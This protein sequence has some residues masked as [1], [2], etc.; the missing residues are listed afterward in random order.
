[1]RKIG[2]WF[3]KTVLESPSEMEK[4][5]QFFN[6][7]HVKETLKLAQ[8]ISRWGHSWFSSK[9]SPGRPAVE[10]GQIDFLTQL[11]QSPNPESVF[12]PEL[13]RKIDNL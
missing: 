3:N 4:L 10:T 2:F 11:A 12:P 9:K 7:L 5:S 6:A 1:M 8:G 13:I